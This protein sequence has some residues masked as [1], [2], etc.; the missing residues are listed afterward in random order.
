M[1]DKKV[2]GGITFDNNKSKALLKDR[3]YLV[4]GLIFISKTKTTETLP[5]IILRV[6]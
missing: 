5:I 4:A 3:A 6:E 2:F 1:P